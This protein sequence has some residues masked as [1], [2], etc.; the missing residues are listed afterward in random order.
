M[1]HWRDPSLEKAVGAEL[2]N[3]YIGNAKL[4]AASQTERWAVRLAMKM[5]APP[6]RVL[7]VVRNPIEPRKKSTIEKRVDYWQDLILKEIH[8]ALCKKSK[9][10]SK[11]VAA[12]KHSGEVLILAI[13]AGVAKAI[14]VN[15]VVIAALVAALLRIMVL[16]GISVFC[17]NYE[18]GFL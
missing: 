5:N 14:G 4:V 8:T 9:R 13:S 6:P 2:V 1:N 3:R 15:I 10:Y 7:K 18:I 12:L 11:E 16:M 17:K